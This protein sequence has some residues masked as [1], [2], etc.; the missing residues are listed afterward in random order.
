MYAGQIMEERSTESLFASPQHPYT[1]ALLAARPSEAT[2]GGLR[3]FRAW[4]R[5]N[6]TGRADACSVRAA[7]MRRR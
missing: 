5:A 4:C 2:A 6:T 3:P 1:A 7:P